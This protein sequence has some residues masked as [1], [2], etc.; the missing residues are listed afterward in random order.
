MIKYILIIMISGI[1]L[2]SAC[3]KNSFPVRNGSPET[4]YP[5]KSDAM[6]IALMKEVSEILEKI[7]VNDSVYIE[8]NAAIRC[9]HYEDERVLLWDLL[10]PSRSAIYRNRNFLDA[11]FDTAVFERAFRAIVQA[12]GF[13][14]LKKAIVP[15]DDHA[16]FATNN[17][18]RIVTD[19]VI[20]T[21]PEVPALPRGPE[22]NEQEII[23]AL[24][25]V[26]IYFPY[27]ENFI[28]VNDPLHALVALKLA[29]LKKPTL[30]HSDR[31]ADS[32]PGREP[33][34]CSP[35]S[36]KLCYRD[37]TVNDEYAA[38]TPTHIVTTGAV[39]KLPETT[40]PP[41]T[42]PVTRAYHGWSKLSK[43]MDR[44]ISFTGNGG[45]SE[46]K[47]A[48]INGYLK[49][50]DEQVTN[51][52]G[53]VVTVFYTRNDIKK[54]RWKRVFSVWDPNWNYQDIEQIYAVY[55]DDTRG[56]KTF[57]GSVST[58]LTL[59]GK[60]SPGK[61]E[62]QIGYKIEAM[63]QDEI[64]TQ[65]KIDRKSFLADGLNDQGWGFAADGNDFLGAGRDWPVYDGGAVWSYTMMFRSY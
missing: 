12:G 53:D 38:S 14:L 62:G 52:S 20:S 43:Q 65:R 36:L 64:I 5:A 42:V 54:R 28:G 44:L 56:T 31:E 37:V 50:T 11:V 25:D 18:A 29:S 55:E 23:S 58:T 41:K 30:V 6:K 40:E 49:L 63:T 10:N 2:I 59:P 4:E 34:R 15:S 35:L 39:E 33:Y 46:I 48:R 61:V 7:Y 26:A 60:P 47:V 21:V 9:G 8:V 22:I 45:G 17:Q 24:G 57:N 32:G 1:G 27:S 3:K 16:V 13:P 51:F 19:S